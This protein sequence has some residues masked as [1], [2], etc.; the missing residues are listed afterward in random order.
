[1]FFKFKSSFSPS[2]KPAESDNNGCRQRNR[3]SKPPTNTSSLNLSS[4]SLLHPGN[5]SSTLFPLSA[6]TE[7]LQ[8]KSPAVANDEPREHLKSRIVSPVSEELDAPSQLNTRSGQ[9]A[10]CDVNDVERQTSISPT[11]RS[12]IASPLSMLFSTSRLSLL[13]SKEYKDVKERTPPKTDNRSN[14]QSREDLTSPIPIRRKSLLQPG[15]ATRIKKDGRWGPSPPG[16]AGID[17]DRDYYYNPVFP[18]E[19]S[20]SELEALNLETLVVRKPIPPPLVRTETP[21]DLG[22]LG[23]LKLGSLHITNGCSSPAPSDLSK[24][25]KARSTPNLRAA[26]SEYGDSDHEECDT[27]V[28][29]VAREGSPRWPNMPEAPPRFTSQT[30]RYQSPLRFS[31]NIMLPKISTTCEVAV[32]SLQVHER[33][34]DP[35]ASNESPGGSTSMAEDYMA[36]L[37]PS[38][39]AVSRRSSTSDSILNPISKSTEF[40]DN[41]F[42][43]DSV[44]PSDYDSVD[45]STVDTHYS[46]NDVTVAQDT[47]DPSPQESRPGYTLADSGY[48]SNSSLRGTRE[49]VRRDAAVE[50]TKPITAPAAATTAL[51]NELTIPKKREDRRPGPRPLRPSILKQT[52]ATATSL[53]TFENLHQSTTTIST[54]MTTTS[55]PPTHK[56]KKLTKLRLSSRS[57]KSRDISVQGN[58]EVFTG[59]IPPIP[60]E[61]AANL[62]IRS[63]QVPELEH[64]FET[65]QHTTESPTTSHVQHTEIR[66]PSPA[67]SVDG[68]GDKSSAPPRPPPHKVLSFRRRS[69]SDKRSSIH[70]TAQDMSEADALA[71]IQDF[72]TVGHALGG[73]PYDVARTNLES[74]PRRS[75]EPACKMNPHNI[76]S[77][78]K[79]PRPTSGMDAETAAELARSRSR[80]IYERDSM[81]LAE[82]RDMFNDRGGLPGKNLRPRSFASNTPPLPALPPGLGTN[83]RQS[84]APQTTHS[85]VQQDHSWRPDYGHS[86]YDYST[87]R[88][89]VHDQFDDEQWEGMRPTLECGKPNSSTGYSSDYWRPEIDRRQSWRSDRVQID[90]DPNEHWKPT[91]E[92]GD[93]NHQYEGYSAHQNDGSW[94]GWQV[95]HGPPHWNQDE[96][97]D[98]GAP[99]PPPHSPRPMSIAPS[100]GE[101]HGRATHGQAWHARRQSAG[102][103]PRYASNSRPIEENDSL[104]PEIPLRNAPRN[105]AHHATYAEPSGAYHEYPQHDNVPPQSSDESRH[106]YNHGRDLPRPHSQANSHNGSYA[107][108]LAES[109]HPPHDPPRV[110]PS[111]QFGRYSGGFSYGYEHG[112]GFGGSA[113]TR[114]VSG[115]AKASR[116]GKELSQGYGVDLSDVPII[117][118]LKNL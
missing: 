33:R 2:R 49:D 6:S 22:F 65:R 52:G 44:T 101:G 13:S 106:Q 79:R 89:P 28:G 114:S 48:S 81:S 116:K 75:V 31:S 71:V 67:A 97:E 57:S 102:E 17:K 77:A 20:R 55:A 91:E 15:V 53:P 103:V 105:Q 27:D 30:P 70:R 78:A 5:P 46:S 45:D 1:M 110:S 95:P 86:R 51:Q 94:P 47:Q 56:S 10:A 66:F 64:T 113:G 50:E 7:D 98:D 73:N 93:F 76:T 104:Y 74:R 37:P 115:V 107:G 69:R 85:Q 23:G 34:N 9:G 12:P 61:F 8:D 11:S 42:E 60:A 92:E 90:F 4:L 100:E 62:A 84:W 87:N 83:H 14:N 32:Q 59:S 35:G 63:Q 41:L 21:S 25:A 16:E 108:S 40:D 36:E 118:G 58:H 96:A 29:V 26:S 19:T 43:D 82:K 38:P 117:A 111:P 80:T 39:F 24:R 99:P 68:S 3:L 54:V 18:E 88:Q 109:L 112:S 72:G